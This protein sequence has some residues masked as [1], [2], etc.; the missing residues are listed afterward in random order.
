MSVFVL[1]VFCARQECCCILVLVDISG[2]LII[3]AVGSCY[4]FYVHHR[5]CNDPIGISN[6]VLYKLPFRKIS[7]NYKIQITVKNCSYLI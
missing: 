2:L 4:P 1:S 3:T 5:L 7:G 6:A